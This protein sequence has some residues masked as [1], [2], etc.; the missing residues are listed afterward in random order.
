[1]RKLRESQVKM[2]QFGAQVAGLDQCDLRVAYG[3]FLTS[4]PTKSRVCFQNNIECWEK[5]EFNASTIPTY[6]P[7]T[8]S[9]SDR[10]GDDP[11]TDNSYGGHWGRNHVD[12]WP[13]ARK[14]TRSLGC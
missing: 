6:A 5:G 8:D 2:M 13:W 4:T 3:N 12:S 7:I 9:D 10:D 11:D 14:P 1:M